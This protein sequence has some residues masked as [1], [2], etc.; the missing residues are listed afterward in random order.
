MEDLLLH[1]RVSKK[2]K[3]QMQVLIEAGYFNN[4]A[5]VVREGIRS[6]LLRYR[7]ELPDISERNKKR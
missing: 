3:E 7:E 6:T 1:I 5:E 2:I 4:Q